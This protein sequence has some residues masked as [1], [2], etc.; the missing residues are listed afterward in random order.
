M[1]DYYRNPTEP[2]ARKPH[3]CVGCYA[4]I[5]VGERY[6]R[7]TGFYE[8]LSF[9]NKFHLECWH[10]LEELGETEFERGELDPPERLKEKS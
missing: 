8:G 5:A 4:M 10:A 6:M 1:N 2:V 9:C 3:Q 7:Q